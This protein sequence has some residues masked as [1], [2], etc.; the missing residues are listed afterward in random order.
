MAK[1]I[2]RPT[3]YLNNDKSQEVRAGGILFY[4]YN[5]KNF[6]LLLTYSRNNYEDFGG[7]TDNQDIDMIDTVSREAS[8]ESNYVFDQGFLKNKI[9]DQVP[10]YVKHCKYV[11]YFVQ[12]DQDYDVKVFGDKE[13]CD[14]F[15]RTVEWIPYERF[16]DPDFKKNFRLKSYNIA[17]RLKSFLK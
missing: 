10:I 16:I 17:N 2:L 5:D 1:K 12:L 13:I 14:G 8:E 15:D 4:K 11:I 9:K 7:Q 3:F 6:D